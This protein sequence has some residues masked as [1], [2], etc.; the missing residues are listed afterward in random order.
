MSR[1]GSQDLSSG[2]PWTRSGGSV[3]RRAGQAGPWRE[4]G[5]GAQ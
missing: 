2:E 1:S 5:F 3:P 4:H